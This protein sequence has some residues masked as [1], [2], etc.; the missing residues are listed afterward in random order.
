[1]PVVRAVYL[2]LK[3]LFETLSGAVSSREFPNDVRYHLGKYAGT[4]ECPTGNMLPTRWPTH[5]SI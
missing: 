4:S 1:M 3:L 5:T 2:I